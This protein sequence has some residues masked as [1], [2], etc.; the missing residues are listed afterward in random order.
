M[1]DEQTPVTGKEQRERLSPQGQGIS[2]F[3][4]AEDR[5]GG[6]GSAKGGIRWK[7]AASPRTGARCGGRDPS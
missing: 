1:K 5:G 6:K 4:E 3:L 7:T 2:A